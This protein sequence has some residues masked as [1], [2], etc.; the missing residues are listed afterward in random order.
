M[1]LDL[2]DRVALV[3]GAS[4]GLG[5]A[6]SLGL[7]E[8]GVRVVAV[9]RR[10]DLL[11]DLYAELLARGAPEPV[12]VSIDMTAADTPQRLRSLVANGLDILVN[13]VGGSSPRVNDDRYSGILDAPS[14]PEHAWR[15]AFELNFDAGRRLTEAVVDRVRA[16]EDGRIINIT[17]TSEPSGFNVTGPAK[18]AVHAWSKGLSRLLAADGVTVNCV[19]PG[20]LNTEQITVRKHPDPRD[21]ARFAAARIPLGYFGEPEDLAN[22]VVFL[23]SP[24][25]RYITGEIVH[26]D[27]GMKWSAF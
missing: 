8:E 3:T 26:V 1:D 12:T 27:G 14:A 18:A 17:G 9:A 19:A 24:R 11:D 13:N 25:A 4:A 7:A 2:R 5:K 21:R 16:A 23:A 6:I 22:L 15:A 20:R 10:K